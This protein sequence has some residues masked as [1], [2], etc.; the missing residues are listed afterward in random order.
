MGAPS[1]SKVQFQILFMELIFF[2][3]DSVYPKTSSITMIIIGINISPVRGLSEFV[4]TYLKESSFRKG[5][6]RVRALGSRS[7]LVPGQ[8]G[9][10][11]LQETLSSHSS[12]VVMAVH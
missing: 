2:S 9:R 8:F 4:H 7:E 6:I 12:L 5:K 1:V 10:A 11:I 3:R